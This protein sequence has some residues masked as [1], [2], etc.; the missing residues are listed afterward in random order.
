M[1]N[2][3]GFIGLGNM[4]GCLAMAIAEKGYSLSVYDISPTALEV[5]NGKASI[6]ADTVS[7]LDNSNVVFLSLPSSSAVEPILDSFLAFGVE[8]KII[9]DTSTSFP[10][11][12]RTYYTRIKDAGGHLVD[13]PLSGT[14]ANAREGKLLALFGGDSE[15]FEQLRDVVFRFAD[16]YANLGDSGSGHVA[17][18]IFNYIALSYVNIYAMAFPL[19][20]K[21]GLD[22]KQLFQLLQT[23]GMNC[24]ILNFYVPKMIDK[25]YDMAFALELA[26]KDLSYVKAMFEEYQVPAYSLDGVLTLLRTSI[27]AGMGKEDYSACIKTMYQFFEK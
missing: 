9:V 20:E 15:L 12:T 16:R 4:G 18:L 11:S 14:P 8:N 27:C 5:F 17:K 10:M 1:I 22:N 13:L 26:H 7:V 24:G 21:I 23:T 2:S 25:T 6:M 19:T 3:I